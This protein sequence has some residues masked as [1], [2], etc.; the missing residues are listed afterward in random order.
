MNVFFYIYDVTHQCSSSDTLVTM[1]LTY[2]RQRIALHHRQ[3]IA[4]HCGKAHVQSQWERANFD[5]R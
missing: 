2:H 3:R 1:P 5:P 4:L